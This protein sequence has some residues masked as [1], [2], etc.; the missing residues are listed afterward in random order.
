[1]P[2]ATKQAIVDSGPGEPRD[3]EICS[4]LC[5]PAAFLRFRRPRPLAPHRPDAAMLSRRARPSEIVGAR[6]ALKV[7]RVTSEPQS[8]EVAPSSVSECKSTYSLK[9]R[10]RSANRLVDRKRAGGVTR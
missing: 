8:A 1:M 2:S 4:T 5:R 6:I 7:A 9:L 3:L 10:C